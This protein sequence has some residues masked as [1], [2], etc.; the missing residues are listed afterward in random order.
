MVLAV[1]LTIMTLV[2]YGLLFWRG[3]LDLAITRAIAL[4]FVELLMVTSIAILFSSF[5][6]PIL[7]SLFTVTFYLIGHLTWG[8]RLLADR[9]QGDLGKMVCRVLYGILPN[10]ETL[11]VKGMVVHG[12]QVP[13]PQVA[14]GTIYGVSYAVIFLALAA[15]VFR[16]RDFL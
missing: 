1:N 6:T 14:F 2:F 3:W 11:N 12:E 16:R 10:L 5:S 15:L 13:L 4:I 8:L 7:S 9:V